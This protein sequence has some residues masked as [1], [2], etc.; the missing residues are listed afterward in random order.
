MFGWLRAEAALASRRKRSS[1]WRC[2]AVCRKKLQSDKTVKPG[3]LRLVDDT[4]PSTA[5]L[6]DNA[7]VRDGLADH[8][9]RT[10][11]FQAAPS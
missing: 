5:E 9:R 7:V 10:L 2:S 8:G 11:V 1:D 6:F 4:H 3:I